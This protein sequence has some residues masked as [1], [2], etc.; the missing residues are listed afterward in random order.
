MA[1]EWQKERT[2]EKKLQ[3]EL[4]KSTQRD[5]TLRHAIWATVCIISLTITVALICN[6]VI[7]VTKLHTGIK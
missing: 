7:S 1:S 5:S 2:E 3:I 4:N 6:T